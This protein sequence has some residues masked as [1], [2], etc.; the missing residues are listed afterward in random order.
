M[1]KFITLQLIVM[2]ILALLLTSCNGA[3]E[4][5]T[6]ITGG[7]T[8]TSTPAEVTGSEPASTPMSIIEPTP[9]PTPT[10]EPGLAKVQLLNSPDSTG[11]THFASSHYGLHIAYGNDLISMMNYLTI[12]Q[13]GDDIYLLPDSIEDFEY[14]AEDLQ[15]YNGILYFLI[16]DWDNSVYYLYSYDFDNEP[17]KVSDSA[18]YH[19]EFINGKIYFRK[20]FTQGPIFSMDPNGGNEIQISTMR[21]HNFVHSEQAIYFFA[22]DAGTAPGL[23]KYDLTT[24]EETT[25]V[26]PFYSHNYLVHNGYVYYTLDSGNYR[27]IHRMAL[28][29]QS[30]TDIWVEMT[31]W[32][33]SMNISDGA[34]YMLVGD[35]IYKSN[36]DGS[37]R[38]KIFMAEDNLQTGL[39]IFG[40]RIY[41]ADGAFVYCTLTDGSEV[42]M[43]AF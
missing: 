8:Q 11:N 28:S 30:E 12:L 17:V 33:I 18:V 13:H 22:T 10:P 23:V 4:T 15:F 32:T 40:D 14:Q 39:Y 42:S 16:Y 19:Y 3:A 27:S 2:F 1:K 41:C 29:D 35:S 34:L 31:D 21:A 24:N 43:F 37:G 20:E 36:L 5:Q 6:P 7:K 25:V 9:S 38:I 26:F